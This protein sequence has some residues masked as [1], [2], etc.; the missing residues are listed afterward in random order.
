MTEVVFALLPNAVLLD[1]AGPADAFRNAGTP[2][3]YRLHFVA[4]QTD[5][6]VAGGLT[7]GKLEPLPERLAPGTFLV[8]SGVGGPGVDPKEPATR[9]LIAWLRSGVSTP[10]QL[11]C[12]CS[13][14]LV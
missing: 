12:I 6:T 7:L 4:P 1:V 2:G 9:R 3:S 5:V 8:L 14:S 13:G 10:A 11:V